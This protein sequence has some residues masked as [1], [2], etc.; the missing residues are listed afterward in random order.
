MK[1]IV[2]AM[3]GDN[4]PLSIVEG[5]ALAA[6][7]LGAKLVLVG[8]GDEILKSMHSLSM[9][10][11]PDGV[12]I[13]NASE[14]VDMHDDPVAA[15]RAKKDSSLVVG[16]NLLRDGEGSAFVSAGST[17]ALLA[18]ATLI[19]KRIKGIRRAALAPI[20]PQLL[21]N[22]VIIDSGA[23]IDCTPEFLLQFAVMGSSLTKN[24]F[25]KSSPKVGLLNIGTEDTKGGQ[26]QLDAYALLKS[27]GESGA[28]NF[29][30]NIEARDVFL[31]DVDVVVSDGFSGNVLLKT[32]EGMGLFFMRQMRS[33]LSTNLRTKLGGMLI[34]SAFKDLRAQMDYTEVGGGILLGVTKP[35]VKAHGSSDAKAIRNAIAFALKCAES[36]Y[37]SDI[38]L[39]RSIDNDQR[40]D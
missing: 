37:I 35:V 24:V 22:R 2:D 29:I 27:A 3:G 20:M 34:K 30:G 39:S 7:E 38:E 21:G 16:L 25:G 40:E 11:L 15:V 18:G 31:G 23:N 33:L 36:N 4:A 13:A 10:T 9:D 1:I 14:L 26:L 12:E 19:I 5:S 8:R 28:L 6:V 32:M 17:G